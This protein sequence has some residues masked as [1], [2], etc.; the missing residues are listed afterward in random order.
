MQHIH[1]QFAQLTAPLAA[2][3]RFR[4][5]CRWARTSS[6]MRAGTTAVLVGFGALGVTY[7]GHPGVLL[8]DV[9]LGFRSVAAR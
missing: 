5:R 1:E 3:P 7:L 2:D 6:R 8:D 9:A 4:W